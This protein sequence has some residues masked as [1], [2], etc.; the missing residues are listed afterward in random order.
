MHPC[1]FMYG[2][3]THVEVTACQIGRYSSESHPTSTVILIIIIIHNRVS[4]KHAQYL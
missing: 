3:G 2:K 1:V 4:G